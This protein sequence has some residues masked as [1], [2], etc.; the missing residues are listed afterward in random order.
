MRPTRATIA[1][2]LLVPALGLAQA[3][4]AP[5]VDPAAAPVDPYERFNRRVFA[6]NE[7]LDRALV[8]PL[9]KGYERVTPRGF[10][11]MV[12]NFLAN[13]RLPLSAA[14]ALLQG[15]P[16]VAGRN[17]RRFGINSTVGL[18][19]LFDPATGFGVHPQ[20]E[21]LGQTLAVW[22]MPEGPYLVLP[23]LGPSGGRDALGGTA[24]AF[25]DPVAWYARSEPAYWLSGLDLLNLR[26]SLFATEPY[27]E[28]AYDAY[29]FVRDAYRQR[30]LYAVWDG[31]PPDELL[32]QMLMPEDDPADLLE[33]DLP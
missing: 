7:R 27:V 31:E 19:G 30:R 15:K 11:T 25:T 32:E 23:L 3:L 6:F 9:A 29:S 10:R 8:R 4:P 33:D 24:D 20:L 17:L 1:L 28:D 26:V 21:D 2:L 22:G 12:G 13:V 18:L 16:R 14:H 5:P